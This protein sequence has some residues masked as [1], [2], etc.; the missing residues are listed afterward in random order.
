MVRKPNEVIIKVN[1]E[2]CNEEH[3]FDMTQLQ[4]KR[5]TKQ[6]DL[7]QNIFPEM[8]VDEREILVSGICSSCYDKMFAE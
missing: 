6:K 7:I 8:S 4:Y 2:I 3:W 1:C 5:W